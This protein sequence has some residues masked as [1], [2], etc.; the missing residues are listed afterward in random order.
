MNNISKKHKLLTICIL[1]IFWL[2]YFLFEVF[3]GRVTDLYT[4]VLN[5]SL[6]IVFA[7]VGWIIYKVSELYANGFTAKILFIIFSILLLLDQGLKII[8]GKFFFYDRFEII[9]DFLSFHPIINTHGSWLNARFDFGVNFSFLIFINCIALILII[10]IYRYHKFKGNKSFWSDMCLV[11]ILCGAL[12]SLIDKV[13]YGGSLDFIGISD[14][15]IADI[16]D[17]YINIGLLFFVMTSYING[18]FDDDTSTT[19][20]EDIQGIKRFLIFIK[21]DIVNIIKKEKA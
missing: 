8:I 9:P 12:C 15:F 13:F 5:L 20:K 16:K 7:F 3:T 11:F 6:T 10:E 2:L 1:P 4:L 18:Y 17:I 19:L 14:L 21:N